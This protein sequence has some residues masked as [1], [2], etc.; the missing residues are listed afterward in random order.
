MDKIIHSRGPQF[1]IL[2]VLSLKASKR[3]H[4]KW[5]VS[6]SNLD[7]ALNLLVQSK[8]DLTLLKPFSKLWPRKMNPLVSYPPPPQ[9]GIL[10]IAKPS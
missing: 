3:N 4:P 10:P 2:E 8:F 9:S 6:S 7:R 5:N 1:E